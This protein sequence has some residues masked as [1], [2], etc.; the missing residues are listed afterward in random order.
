MSQPITV[1]H[2]LGER[3]LVACGG[4]ELL[5]Y[6][7]AP[8]P[9]PFEA[10]RPYLHP[11]RTLTGGLVSGYRPNDHRWHKGLQLAGGHLSG[12]NFWGGDCLPGRVSAAATALWSRT[13]PGTA[14]TPRP[15]SAPTGGECRGPVLG[16]ST[17]QVTS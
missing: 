7:Y 4:V 13:V 1:T 6:V 9:D 11:L 15:T 12:Q 17:T 3:I 5:T 2:T 10:R 16:G 8:D 14:P